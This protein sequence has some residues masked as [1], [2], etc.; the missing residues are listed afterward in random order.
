MVAVE[1][2]NYANYDVSEGTWDN[3]AFQIRCKFPEPAYIVRDPSRIVRLT[4]ILDYTPWTVKENRKIHLCA[5]FFGNHVEGWI[6][7]DKILEGT[8][9]SNHP[10]IQ[11]GRIALWTFETWSEFD[12][13]VVRRLIPQKT[14]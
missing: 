1:I 2:G 4:D 5:K 13:L 11:R 9:P 14:H 8:I 12:N 3:A 6:N 10:G 7:G